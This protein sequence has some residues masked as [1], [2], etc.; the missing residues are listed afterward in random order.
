MSVIVG[1]DFKV[2]QGASGGVQRLKTKLLRIRFHE[3]E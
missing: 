3:L 1:L 2:S